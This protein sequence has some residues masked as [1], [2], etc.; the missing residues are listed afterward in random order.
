MKILKHI[1]M[2]AIVACLLSACA[3]PY[4]TEKSFWT[5]GKG[6][7]T[8]QI[9]PDSWQISFVGNTNT[10]RALTQK[11]VMIKSAELC[12]KAGYDYFQYTNA[13]TNSD[14]VGQFGAGSQSNNILFGSTSID[15]ETSTV[16][17]VTGL[18]TKPAQANT[19]VY[20]VNYILNHVKVDN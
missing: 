17:E 15:K 9:A 3:T 6:F 18:K 1:S 7:E 13:Q 20:D 8:V 10:D 19:R 4:N 16:V 5:F 14:A 11:Y 2:L 12:Q